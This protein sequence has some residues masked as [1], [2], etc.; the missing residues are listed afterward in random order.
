[1]NYVAHAQPAKDY[2]SMPRQRFSHP[3]YFSNDV[4]ANGLA[5]HHGDPVPSMNNNGDMSDQQMILGNKLH[6]LVQRQQ[7]I[8][9]VIN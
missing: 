8:I 2:M 7:V 4:V 1:M 6:P 9:T 5:I 3:K